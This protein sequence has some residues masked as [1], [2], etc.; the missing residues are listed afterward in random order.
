M[1]H[2]GESWSQPSLGAARVK[3]GQPVHV[4]EEHGRPE[5]DAGNP[6]QVREE[7]SEGTAQ[8]QKGSSVG[9][10]RG[11]DV[12]QGWAQPLRE[13]ERATWGTLQN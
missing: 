1:C 10:V 3:E 8:A 7:S 12:P 6:V 11:E 9:N 4:G 2:L 5:R 13:L